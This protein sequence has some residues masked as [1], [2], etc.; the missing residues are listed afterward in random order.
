MADTAVQQDVV[1]NLGVKLD[2]TSQADQ[3]DGLGLPAP[4]K[5]KASSGAA[6]R[7]HETSASDGR[8]RGHVQ[9]GPRP[10]VRL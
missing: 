2:P 7:D 8:Y 6:R 5:V 1:L 4:R 9:Q 10:I 3:G